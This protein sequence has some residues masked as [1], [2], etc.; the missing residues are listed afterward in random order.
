MV[1]Q[2]RSGPPGKPRETLLGP[3]A[4]SLTGQGSGD[5]GDRSG[6]ARSVTGL[7]AVAPNR[8][9]QGRL[10]SGGAGSG[11][12]PEARDGTVCQRDGLGPLWLPWASGQRPGR[13]RNPGRRPPV[14]GLVWSA[15][16][17]T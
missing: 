1:G 7:G 5:T 12:Q 13:A 15:R 17:A 9:G 2:A 3:Q 16:K 8:S 14:S 4:P 10:P 6:R 11:E